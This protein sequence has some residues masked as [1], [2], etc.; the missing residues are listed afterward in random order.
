MHEF[1]QLWL[2]LVLWPSRSICK[3]QDKALLLDS[4]LSFWHAT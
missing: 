4:T 1:W 3:K 2:L